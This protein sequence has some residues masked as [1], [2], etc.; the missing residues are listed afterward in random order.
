MTGRAMDEKETL[1]LLIRCPSN[2]HSKSLRKNAIRAYRARNR[3]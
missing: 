2:V 3:F 1:K